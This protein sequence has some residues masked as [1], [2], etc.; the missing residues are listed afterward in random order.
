M[1]SI[2][3]SPGTFRSLSDLK[4]Q[5]V[6]NP[7]T[8]PAEANSALGC[9]LLG[10]ALF[11]SSHSLSLSPPTP[12]GGLE[13]HV[14]IKPTHVEGLE[15]NKRHLSRTSSPRKWNYICIYVFFCKNPVFSKENMDFPVT[16]HPAFS[17]CGLTYFSWR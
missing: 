1:F 11:S 2:S 12:F 9:L 16:C 7:H 6:L 15:I 3:K 17:C 14:A 5:T 8:D 13:L 4:Q 10:S